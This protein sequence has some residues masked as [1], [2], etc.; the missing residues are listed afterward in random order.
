MT[1]RPSHVKVVGFEARKTARRV[2]FDD[3]QPVIPPTLGGL[4]FEASTGKKKVSEIPSQRTSRY[5][6]TYL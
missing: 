5:S 1:W 2:E 6:G 3:L 4:R